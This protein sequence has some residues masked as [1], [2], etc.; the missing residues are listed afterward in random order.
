[1]YVGPPSLPQRGTSRGGLSRQAGDTLCPPGAAGQGMVSDRA[2][3]DMQER[4]E[5][6]WGKGTKGN[7]LMES[8]GGYGLVFIF[9]HGQL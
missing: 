1:M 8:R 3:A 4:E 2:Q 7:S 6:L 5:R 9:N